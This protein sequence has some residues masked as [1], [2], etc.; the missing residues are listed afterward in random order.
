MV[1]VEVLDLE[2]WDGPG[3]VGI[4]GWELCGVCCVA[5]VGRC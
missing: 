4:V 1:L 2:L 5:G 3:A